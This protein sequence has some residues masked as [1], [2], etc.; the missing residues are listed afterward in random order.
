MHYVTS[1]MH[2]NALRDLQI[3]L[4]ANTQVQPSHFLCDPHMAHLRIKNYVLMF[5]ALGAPEGTT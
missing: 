2:Y 1:P 3:A 5:C 4:D